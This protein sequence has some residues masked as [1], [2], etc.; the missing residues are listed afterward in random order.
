MADENGIIEFACT[1]CGKP[2]RCRYYLPAVGRRVKSP[3]PRLRYLI[4]MLVAIEASRAI[5]TEPRTRPVQTE[6]RILVPTHGNWAGCL[7]LRHG[8]GAE[9]RRWRGGGSDGQRPNPR[10]PSRAADKQ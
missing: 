10:R 4:R 9:S 8:N 7:P 5:S 6:S 1:G 2:F 3:A